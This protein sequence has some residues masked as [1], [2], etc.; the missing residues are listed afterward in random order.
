MQH[1]EL[2]TSLL[3]TK[4]GILTSAILTADHSMGL[5]MKNHI[6]EK[7]AMDI[8][9]PDLPNTDIVIVVLI[10]VLVVL[11]ITIA[12]QVTRQS[13]LSRPP[14]TLMQKR[15]VPFAPAEL[16]GKLED[17]LFLRRRMLGG[18]IALAELFFH[19]LLFAYNSLYIFHLLFAIVPSCYCNLH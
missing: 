16:M 9:L 13:Q 4:P 17:Q 15:P 11:D 6:K 8:L 12:G 7:T 19:G 3:A 2:S 1:H 14:F 5:A 10:D 18:K